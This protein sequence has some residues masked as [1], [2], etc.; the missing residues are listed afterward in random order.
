MNF[1]QLEMLLLSEF[2]L[3]WKPQE[4]PENSPFPLLSVSCRL[5][6]HPLNTTKFGGHL[7]ASPL[8]AF[9]WGKMSLSL[10]SLKYWRVSANWH[11]YASTPLLAAAHLEAG[12]CSQ[13]RNQYSVPAWLCSADAEQM[14]AQGRAGEQWDCCRAHVFENPNQPSTELG[15]SMQHIWGLVVFKISSNPS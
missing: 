13:S 10:S 6:K 12:M 15:H 9:P 2:L 11:L 7:S 4:L 8:T 1:I 5:L 3:P 14:E